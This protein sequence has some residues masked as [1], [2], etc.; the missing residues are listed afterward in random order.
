MRYV[1]VA[2]S[3]VTGKDSSGLGTAITRLS[4][5]CLYS[6]IGG[7]RQSGFGVHTLTDVAMKIREF[8]SRH[9]LPN[10]G[11]QYTDSGGYSIIRG[12]VPP[13]AVR[14]FI[15]CYNLYVENETA[16]FERLFSLDIPF[17]R[18]HEALNTRSAL[19]DFNRE[20]LADLRELLER[21]PGLRDKLFFVWHFKMASQYAIWRQLYRELELGRFITHRAIGGMVGM[22][23]VT[24]KA[25]SPFT[26]MAF[27]CLLDFLNDN[28]G[29][30]EFRLHFLGMYIPYDRFQIALLEKLFQGW[31]GDG[32][33]VA[34]SYD[35]INF[36]HTARMNKQEPV[37]HL[38]GEALV[39][40]PRVWDVDMGV[41]HHVYGPAV[42][43][44]L[45]E[46]ALRKQGKKLQDCNAFGPLAIH[47]NLCLDRFFAQVIER[48]GLA[49]LLA[50]GS[51]PT[52]ILGKG[53]GM[54]RDLAA[55]HPDVFTPSMVKSVQENLEITAV[56]AQWFRGSRD[57]D[58]LEYRM[59]QFITMCGFPDLIR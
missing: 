4:R 44:A 19:L 15:K 5:D 34:M 39:S 16:H 27:R 42:D 21:S 31:L 14:R 53:G 2:D 20:S 1:Y 37:R 6:L 54:L 59:G 52:V 17:S 7:L 51:S 30:K 35:S 55:A 13:Q 49:D 48:Y 11:R 3:A 38:D 41:L 47:S 32:V 33:R 56:Y 12:D 29:E 25:F 23:G 50:K 57:S 18:K 36:A 9:I 22:R 26:P 10:G 46:I 40:F 28:P 45:S 24:K 58:D 8:R 43:Y